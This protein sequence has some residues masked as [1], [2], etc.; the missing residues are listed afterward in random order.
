VK[1]LGSLRELRVQNAIINLEDEEEE[2]KRDLLESVRHLHKLQHLKISCYRSRILFRRQEMEFVLPGDLRY[3]DL[4]GD[5]VLWKLPSCIDLLCHRKLSH[6]D[7][8]LQYM[9]MDEQ[10]LKTLGGLPE[11]RFLGLDLR[12]ASPTIRN[13]SDSDVCYFPKLRQLV[14]RRSMVLFVASK[15]DDGKK[16]VSFHIWDG[17]V[18]D[19]V[20]KQPSAS[21]SELQGDDESSSV[22]Q[23]EAGRGPVG[24]K[25][26]EELQ[27]LSS[28]DDVD[29]PSRPSFQPSKLQHVSDDGEGAAAPRFMPRL[30]V[31]HFRVREQAVWDPR[32]CNNIGLEFLSSLQ[33]IRV[34][35][36][37][38]FRAS[39]GQVNEVKAAL[40][41]AAQVHPNHPTLHIIAV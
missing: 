11:L 34:T 17:K 27:L 32:Y 10:E 14:L 6:L 36:D 38:R 5:I 8:R 25:S 12:R 18:D 1:E 41:S 33:E 22:F 13:I 35:M 37:R 30:Q 7:L 31:L 21:D 24:E 28:S 20:T 15:G 16:T 19:S 40:R 4:C 39:S 3:L 29:P 23:W 9:Y 26:D 2:M